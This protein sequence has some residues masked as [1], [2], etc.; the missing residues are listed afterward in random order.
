MKFLLFWMT[1]YSG[2]AGSAAKGVDAP[3]IRESL[4]AHIYVGLQ[5]ARKEMED[6]GLQLNDLCALP[7]EEKW[8][9]PQSVKYLLLAI[10]CDD[11]ESA[12]A[13]DRIAA[14]DVQPEP[15]ITGVPVE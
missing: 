15:E 1:S 11:A 9:L 4:L 7:P 6:Y 13:F 5:E 14:R 10:K 3:W 12:A 2:A 8:K